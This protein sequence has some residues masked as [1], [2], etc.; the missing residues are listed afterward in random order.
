VLETF[1]EINIR[2][3]FINKVRFQLCRPV[4]P[5]QNLIDDLLLTGMQIF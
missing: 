5:S 2:N 3:V 4:C 1:E